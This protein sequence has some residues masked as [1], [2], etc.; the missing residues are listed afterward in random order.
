MRGESGELRPHRHGG[1]RRRPTTRSRSTETCARTGS[2]TSASCSRRACAARSTTSPPSP[3]S[4]R[5]CGCARAST[6]SRPTI[7]LPG[8]RRRSVRTSSR[9]SALLD[10]GAYVAV[11]THDELADRPREGAARG[12]AACGRE[13]YEF[14]MLLG[15]RRR[16]R[17]PARA[18]GPPP[19]HLRPVRAPLVRVLDATP[20]GE[21]GDRDG[22]I[23]KATVSR[24][25]PGRNGRDSE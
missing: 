14:Q 24:F 4:V 12:S 11:A 10:A 9:R 16:A 13:E 25:L 17:R 7:A 23:A 18:R 8:L 5:T 6:S 15:V 22:Y 2:T 21:P 19:A 20:A 1:S 3:T